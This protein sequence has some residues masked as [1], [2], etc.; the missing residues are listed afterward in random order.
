VSA[1]PKYNGGGGGGGGGTVTSVSSTTAGITVA[2]PTTTPALTLATLDAIAVAGPPAANWSNNSKKITSLANGTA[3]Q[4]AAA[5]GQIPTRLTPTTVK[6]SAY[7]A[8][9]SDLVACDISAGSFTVT[10]PTAPGDETQIC[11]EIVKRLTTGA[12]FY[13]TIAAGGTDVLFRPAG[14]ASGIFG[15]GSIVLQYQLST[16]VWFAPGNGDLLPIGWEFG[17]DL[18]PGGTVAI[19]ATT[20]TNA[21]TSVVAAAAH[22]FDGSPVM[23]TV[24]LPS[25]VQSGSGSGVFFT[26][27]IHG[28]AKAG[29]IMSPNTA[30][31]SVFGAPWIGRLRFTPAAMSVQYDVLAYRSAGSNASVFG[32]GAASVQFTKV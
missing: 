21:A 7:S 16:G 15:R 12:P 14:P 4:D 9:P 6:T 5:F 10:L 27:Y 30:S 17:Y 8:N 20:D 32:S 31:G 26:L 29:D 2:N 13:V 24:T 18:G 23:A 11:V 1:N 3:A 22:V 28:G 25:G 19:S